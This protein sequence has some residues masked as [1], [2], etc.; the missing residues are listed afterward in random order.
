MESH[1]EAVPFHQSGRAGK[2]F[3]AGI[4][5]A[6]S[7]VLINPEFLFRVESEPKNIRADGVYRI[8]DLEL[9]WPDCSCAARG[10][11]H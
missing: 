2:D 5:R 4:A 7:D 11:G 10:L 3:D 9:G 1:D 8:S 6:L